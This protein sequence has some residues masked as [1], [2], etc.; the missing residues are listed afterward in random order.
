MDDTQSRTP[1]L[2]TL[3]ATIR[4]RVQNVGFRVF[5]RDAAQRLEVAGYVRNHDD[6]SVC[7]L[8]VGAREALESLLVAL[9]R[10]PAHARVERVEANW[11]PG[12]PHCLYASF[13][14]RP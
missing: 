5:A 2:Q 8:A 12:N 7:V 10:G 1:E 9:Q 3:S 14:V 6:G 11:L 4:G 13:E